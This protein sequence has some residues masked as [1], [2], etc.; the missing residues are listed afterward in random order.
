MTRQH[1]KSQL[2]G[3][4]EFNRSIAPRMKAFLTTFTTCEPVTAALNRYGTL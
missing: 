4:L 2:K 3:Y 1:Q